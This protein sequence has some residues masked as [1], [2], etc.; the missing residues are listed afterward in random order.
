[1][2][3]VPSVSIITVGGVIKQLLVCDRQGCVIDRGV[4]DR[5]GMC[6]RQGW[7]CNSGCVIARGVC[8]R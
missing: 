3:N 6:D 4:C 2:L 5:Q 1:M 7:V 8:E